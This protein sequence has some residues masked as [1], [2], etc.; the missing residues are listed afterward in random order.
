MNEF[1][2]KISYTVQLVA[3]S[4]IFMAPI[5]KRAGFP[6]RAA[7]GAAILIAAAYIVGTV[8]GIPESPFGAIVYWAAFPIAMLPYVLLCADVDF[9]EAAGAV[10]F[11][12]A[13]QHVTC[14]IF[15]IY[16]SYFGQNFWVF[17]IIFAAFYSLFYVIFAERLARGGHYSVSTRDLFP[18]ATLMLF[19][20]VL[21]VLQSFFEMSREARNVYYLSDGLCCLYILWQQ[22]VQRE[23]LEL[24]RE[25]DG[26]SYLWSQ[27]KSQYEVTQETIDAINRKCHDLKHQIAILRSEVGSDKKLEYL[28]QVERE[29]SAYEAQNKTGNQVLD[30][31]LTGKSQ[32]C[33]ENGI[34]F[35]CVADGHL[36][37]FMSVMDISAIFGN[38]LD[39]AIESVMKIDNPEERLIHLS[40]SM[41]RRFVSIMVRN[42]YRDEPI[43]RHG[44]PVTTKSETA[45]HGY[46][47][48]SIKSTAEKYGGAASVAT[49]EGWFELSVLIPMEA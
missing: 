12:S 28:D 27:Q 42:R 6:A 33:H 36:L 34:S 35:T 10:V 1:W 29:I 45:I 18:M 21:S 30:A 4:L 32:F 3:A 40:V 9:G 47:I 48:K 22:S 26:V 8:S 46:G 15:I 11:A 13:V 23:K 20:I 25:L 31:I 43:F 2:M 17:L 24:Q 44:L 49:R 7:A 5:K 41:Q 39:N 19:V 16:E 37:D 38:A 14:N